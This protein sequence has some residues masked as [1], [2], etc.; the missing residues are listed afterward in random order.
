MKLVVLAVGK[1]RDRHLAALTDDYLV[2]ARRHLPIEVVEVED[3]QALARRWP[4]DGETIALEPD[5]EAWT[6]EV[7]ASQMERRMTRGTRALTFV[8]GGADGIPAA[9]SSRAKLRLS[10]SPL[11]L[12]HRL[13]RL[14]LC[15]QLYRALT[16]I[17]HEPYHH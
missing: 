7:F 4:T 3:D 10:L 5:G 16:I 13:A 9:L 11:T 2:R 17:R 12:P 1:L 15:E 14:V 8:I 6:T